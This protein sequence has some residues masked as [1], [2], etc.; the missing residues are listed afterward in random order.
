[1]KRGSPAMKE[2]YCVLMSVYHGEKAEHLREACESMLSQTVPPSQFVLVCDGELTPGLDEVISK[3]REREKYYEN[4][5]IC[6]ELSVDNPPEKCAD[7][8]C[9]KIKDY[10]QT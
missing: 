3:F 9:V 2:R 7:E 4:C 6:I 5:D 10:K 8:I 1:M